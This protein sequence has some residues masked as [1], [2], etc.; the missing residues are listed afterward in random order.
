MLPPHH[1]KF[2]ITFPNTQHATAIVVPPTTTAAEIVRLLELKPGPALFL[3]GGAGLMSP[4]DVALTTDIIGAIA[5]LAQDRGLTV[6]DGGTESGVMQ[7]IGDAHKRLGCTFPLIGVAPHSRV[8]YPGFVNPNADAELEDTHTHFVLVDAPDWGDESEL[9][10][11]MARSVASGPDD[12]AIGV[13]INGGKIASK[14][15]AYAVANN[16]PI[17]VLEGSGRFAD[18]VATA[19]KTGNAKQSIV[20]AILAGGDIQLVSTSEGPAGM[21]ARLE[22]RF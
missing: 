20:R 2:E 11:N 15:I 18:E 17:I 16:V 10:I 19:F 7:M 1:E 12:K 9:L 5:Q 8:A 3:S 6:F 4:E 14:D 22:A 21:R 13:L